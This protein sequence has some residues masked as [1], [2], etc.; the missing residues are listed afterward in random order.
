MI[1]HYF[2]DTDAVSCKVCDV[3]LAAADHAP[4]AEEIEKVYQYLISKITDEGLSLKNL[5]AKLNTRR[6]TKLM[7]II[8]YLIAEEKLIMSETGMLNMHRR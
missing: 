1:A 5:T 7:T 6:K 4:T 2:G 8:E 3:C